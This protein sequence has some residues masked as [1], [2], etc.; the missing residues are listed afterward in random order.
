MDKASLKRL[1]LLAK[2]HKGLLT[3]CG[4]SSLHAT[5]ARKT[6]PIPSESAR[7]AADNHQQ[8]ERQGYSGSEG[9]QACLHTASQSLNSV[10]T[11]HLHMRTMRSLSALQR[12]PSCLRALRSPLSLSLR[13]AR[14]AC[15]PAIGQLFSTN[16]KRSRRGDLL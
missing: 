12:L 11:V 5:R 10:G 15:K 7:R 4:G 14:S 3:A 13:V 6:L 2:L 8:V 16:R 1:T 9:D